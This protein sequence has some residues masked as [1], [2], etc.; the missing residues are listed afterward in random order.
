MDLFIFVVG[1]AEFTCIVI[2]RN[3]IEIC[4]ENNKRLEIKSP[5]LQVMIDR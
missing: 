1:E 2:G 3:S 5:L 4:K